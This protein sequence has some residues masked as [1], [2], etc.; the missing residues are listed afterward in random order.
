MTVVELILGWL[1]VTALGIGSIVAVEPFWGPRRP[2]S[3]A[4]VVTLETPRDTDG[5]R[6]DGK[7]TRL[8]A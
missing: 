8:A 6:G 2:R 7:G 4:V 1:I 3:G 5:E